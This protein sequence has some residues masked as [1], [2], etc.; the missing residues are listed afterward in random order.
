MEIPAEERTGKV[1][2]VSVPMYK[3]LVLQGITNTTVNKAEDPCLHAA[4]DS[5]TKQTDR[6][7]RRIKLAD[8]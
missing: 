1:A 3:E 8:K 4:A 6:K 7:R 2:S 5:L